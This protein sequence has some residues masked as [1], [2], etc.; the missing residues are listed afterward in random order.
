MH[1]SDFPTRKWLLFSRMSVY[2]WGI[3]LN[4]W[5]IQIEIIR[6]LKRG[7]HRAT[8]IEQTVHAAL[9]LNCHVQ[10]FLIGFAFR[11]E[12]DWLW[13][14]RWTCKIFLH[15]YIQ[16]SSRSQPT[17]HPA[18]NN[19]KVGVALS[20]QFIFIQFFIFSA[21]K[22]LVRTGKVVKD[23]SSTFAGTLCFNLTA[24]TEDEMA[25]LYFVPRLRKYQI[26]PALLFSRLML[27]FQREHFNPITIQHAL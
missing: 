13:T 7:N 20:W 16:A 23:Q 25:W 5:I 15:H 22:Q 10:G 1:S 12:T 24:K 26:R 14:K 4:V 3:I 27:R 19:D 6:D 2:S 11:Q 17:P 8:G 21:G 18:C 9:H